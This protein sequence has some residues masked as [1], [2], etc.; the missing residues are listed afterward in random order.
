[1]IGLGDTKGY[2]ESNFELT[3]LIAKNEAWR[4]AEICSRGETLTK[5]ALE[6]WPGPAEGATPD[7]KIIDVT[8]GGYLK[9]SAIGMVY[10]VLRDGEWHATKE[11]EKAAAGKANLDGRIYSIRKRGAKRGLWKLEEKE[12]KYRLQFYSKAGS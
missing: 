3:K 5:R 1:M 6:L 12:G 4:E 9:K 11:L 2:K 10:Q 8:T 7:G